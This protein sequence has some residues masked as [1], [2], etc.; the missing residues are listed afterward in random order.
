MREERAAAPQ[1][2]GQALFGLAVQPVDVE[3]LGLFGEDRPERFEIGAAGRLVEGDAEMVGI[4]RPEVDPGVARL[5][6]IV[7]A[8]P[9]TRTVSVSKNASVATSMPRPAQPFG[10]NR[11]QAV[12]P[13]SDFLEAVGAVIDGVHRGHDRQQHLRGADVAGRLLAPDVLLA[14][15]ERHA[16]RGAA[17]R[18]H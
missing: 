8:W 7:A 13:S 9:G 10:Q 3:R 1:R 12:H 15:L 2:L 16:K 17:P 5:A 4:D 14:R 18:V 6:A 11:G